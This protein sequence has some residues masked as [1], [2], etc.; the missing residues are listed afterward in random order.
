[1][2]CISQEQT[3]RKLKQETMAQLSAKQ[4]KLDMLRNIINQDS[5]TGGSNGRLRPIGIHCHYDNDDSIIH[6]TVDFVK[7]HFDFRLLLTVK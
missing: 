7:G 1:M 6:N 4:H 5:D 3:A 2:S